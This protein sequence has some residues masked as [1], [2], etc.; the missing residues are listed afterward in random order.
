MGCLIEREWDYCITRSVG[1]SEL[2]EELDQYIATLHA[3]KSKTI[4]GL[5]GIVI[6][7]YRVMKCTENDNWHLASSEYNDY[8]FCHNDIC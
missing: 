2:P 6:P 8:V 1:M 7:P 3:L 5:S 4:G